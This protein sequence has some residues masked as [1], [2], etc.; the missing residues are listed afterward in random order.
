VCDTL[1]KLVYD[2]TKGKFDFMI[3]LT[4]VGAKVNVVAEGSA[5]I[6][7]NVEFVMSRHAGGSENTKIKKEVA[8]QYQPPRSVQK[9]IKA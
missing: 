1:N 8:G 6:G 9:I 3:L 5:A 4:A 7:A 2:V